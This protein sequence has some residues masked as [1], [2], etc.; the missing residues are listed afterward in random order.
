MTKTGLKNC[1]SE[2]YRTRD[3]LFVTYDISD[4]ES[5][6]APVENNNNNNNILQVGI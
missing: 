5:R 3:T 6:Y 1:P 2:H 4:S